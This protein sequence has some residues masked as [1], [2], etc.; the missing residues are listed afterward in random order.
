MK[1]KHT[2]YVLMLVFS[3]VP[4]LAFG[5]FMIYENDRNVEEIMRENLE[6]I[7]GTQIL[8][9]KDFCESRKEKMEMIAQLDI[10]HNVVNLPLGERESKEKDYL[11]N[12][13]AEQKETN[14]FLESISIIDK[15]FYIVASTEEYDAERLSDLQ[16]TNERYLTGDF[17]ISNVYERETAEGNQNVVAAYQGIMDNETRIGYVVEEMNVAFFD[18]NRTE[19]NLLEDGTLYLMDG[20]EV[21]ITAGT[22]EESRKAFVT[23]AKERKAYLKALTEADPE[24]NPQ[25]EFSYR[26]KGVDYVTYYSDIDYT[27]WNI[28][29]TINLSRYKNSKMSYRILFCEAGALIVLL[30]MVVNYYISR[31][32]TRAVDH[33][34]S[35]LKKVEDEKNYALRVENYRKDEIGVLAVKVNDMLDYVEKAYQ[36]EKEQQEYLLR[37]AEL[38]SLT[39]VKNKRAIEKYIQKMV[40]EAS[41]SGNRIAIGFVD[42]DDFKDYNTLYGHMEGDRVIQFVASVLKMNCGGEVGRNGG[43]E[44]LFFVNQVR[45][46]KEMETRIRRILQVINGGI[47]TREDGNEISVTC[48]IGLVIAQGSPLDYSH[49]IQAADEA[50]YQAKHEGKNSCRIIEESVEDQIKEDQE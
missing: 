5:T 27:D 36:Q 9:I 38:D 44:F 39:G 11:T 12:L 33:I 47:Y 20:N 7:S 25:G 35:T 32:M 48:S 2:I 49:L 14:E 30:L 1:I 45:S 22:S 23:T 10:V 31:R 46:T 34:A 18:K 6:T 43:D 15:D 42:I 29:V 8:N 17:F 13:L 41:E 50:M 3:L 19:T 4:L 21:L 24:Q 40:Q 28:K 37:K 16:F 26:L